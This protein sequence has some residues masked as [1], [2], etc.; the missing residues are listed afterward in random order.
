MFHRHLKNSLRASLAVHNQIQFIGISVFYLYATFQLELVRDLAHFLAAVKQLNRRV[1]SKQK[2]NTELKRELF[3]FAAAQCIVALSWPWRRIE[4]NY[5]H[6]AIS[7][8]RGNLMASYYEKCKNLFDSGD[9]LLCRI[10]YMK[11]QL[12]S[13]EKPPILKSPEFQKLRT[14]LEKSTH[15]ETPDIMKVCLIKPNSFLL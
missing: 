8:Q 15:I 4:T 13:D 2:A 11:G 10:Y 3:S 14:K 12:N 7:L 1:K 5:Y 9:A 6:T